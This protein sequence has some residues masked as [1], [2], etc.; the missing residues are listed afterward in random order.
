MSQQ[1]IR[2]D[3]RGVVVYKVGDDYRSIANAARRFLDRPAQ[4]LESKVQNVFVGHLRAIA[5]SMTVEDMISDQDKFAQQVRDR[6][7]QEMESFGLVIDSFQIQAIT[8]PS[9]YIE[10]LAVPH[11]AEVEQNARIARANAD[12]E[13]VAQEQT[14][15]AQIAESIRDTEI[16]KAGYQAEIDTGDQDCRAAGT[17]GRGDGAPGGRRGDRHASPSSRRSRRSS[18]SRSTSASPPTPRPTARPRSPP[19]P[20]TPASARPRPRPRRCAC[21][22]RPPRPRRSSRPRR[23]PTATKVQAEAQADATRLNGQAE[24]DAIRAKGTAEADA[25]RA[26]M[27]AEAPGIERRA[28]AL[29]QNQEAVIAQ[30][31]AENLPEVVRAAASSFDHVSNFTVLNG[32]QGV[33]ARAGRDHPA[34]GRP[35]RHGAQRAVAARSRRVDQQATLAE[36]LERARRPR[37]ARR[38]RLDAAAR[39]GGL[40]RGAPAGPRRG[41]PPGAAR[42]RGRGVRAEHPAPGGSR[43]R[44]IG[45]DPGRRP[46]ADRRLVAAFV[47]DVAGP[48]NGPA[49]VRQRL[50]DL[51]HMGA[52]DVLATSQ[53]TAR[54]TAR[55]TDRGA[56]AGALAAGLRELRGIVEELDPPDPDR[57]DAYLDRYAR[58]RDRLDAGPRGPWRG[59]RRARARDCRAPAGRAIARAGVASLRRYAVMAGR[60]DEALE[61]RLA[62]LADTD[63]SRARRLRDDVLAPVR[64]RHRDLLLHLQVATQSLLGAPGP[65]RARRDRCGR[66]CRSPARRP[67]PPSTP[68]RWWRGWPPSVAAGG[69]G[70]RDRRPAAVLAVGV[71]GARAGRPRGPV[72]RLRPRPTAVSLA[73]GAQDDADLPPALR[74]G[75]RLHR[76]AHRGRERTHHVQADARSRGPAARRI[77]A[78]EQVEHP[79]LVAVDEPG[80]AIPHRDR[81]LVL[82][83]PTPGVDRD[84]CPG[85]VLRRVGEEVAQDLLDVAVIARHGRQIALHDEVDASL[86]IPGGL[87]AN[88]PVEDPLEEHR[89]VADQARAPIDVRDDDEVV[90][91]PPEAIGLR[92]HVGGEGSDRRRVALGRPVEEHGCGVDRRDR[93]PQL[94]REHAHEGLPGLV[95]LALVVDIARDRDPARRRFGLVRDRRYLQ[96]HPAMEPV[97][98]S[99]ANLD[100]EGGSLVDRGR[101]R[102]DQA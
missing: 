72:T 100:R 64:S 76:P 1:K 84:R 71:R 98:T 73:R 101:P 87:L 9:D 85:A 8:S 58:S 20:A 36:R 35:V 45:R 83:R 3:L 91:H 21:T 47:A 26:R 69:A 53:V 65:G 74:M 39:D 14:A 86:G 12:R 92:A 50:V 89:V 34:G 102:L 41:E 77:A 67:S 62:E 61:A 11:Q 66:R 88:D 96:A 6:C 51:A 15:Q 42:R 25:I 2:V 68:R 17:A 33:T 43:P 99:D 70:R 78:V 40:G 32:A 5:G 27:E 38:Q 54:I 59:P 55:M 93:G 95:R 97:G 75:S 56:T 81:H 10:N 82:A 24:A 18:S 60:L 31:I 28:A 52:P 94:V 37:R 4:E 49:A 63:P 80:T 7:S 79:V 19:R 48:T 16:K 44:P 23:R 30:Q 13:A 57:L 29:S 22:P 46:G 90:D